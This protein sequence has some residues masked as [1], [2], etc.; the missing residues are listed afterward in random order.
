MSLR[1]TV[2]LFVLFTTL[3]KL[4]KILGLN[5]VARFKFVFYNGNKEWINTIT[6]FQATGFLEEKRVDLRKAEAQRK[7]HE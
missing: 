4:F 3:G 6:Q 5:F 1:M 7:Y 2:P